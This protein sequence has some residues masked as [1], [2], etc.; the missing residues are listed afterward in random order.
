MM[1][2]LA[3]ASNAADWSIGQIRLPAICRSLQLQLVVSGAPRIA[4]GFRVIN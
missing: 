3:K 2:K 1:I 4:E